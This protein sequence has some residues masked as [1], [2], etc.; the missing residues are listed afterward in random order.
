MKLTVF[1]GSPRGTRSNSKLILEQFLGG[2]C[3]TPG[4]EY[5]IFYLN[6]INSQSTLVEVFRRS[7][8]VL[9]AFPL[10]TD[11]MPGIVKAFFESL[12]PFRGQTGNPPVA[13][14]IQYGFSEGIHGQY[15]RRYL[16][17]LA[18]RLNSPLMGIATRGG[19][20]GIQAMPPIITKKLFKQFFELGKG[21]GSTGQFDAALVKTIAR[22]DRF[23]LTEI[24][25]EKVMRMLHVSN[26]YWDQMMKSN[27]AYEKRYDRPSTR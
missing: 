17:K 23:S 21:F 11:A 13:F 26:L 18:C 12:A 20:E 16:E 19:V 25:T 15:L 7:E 9:F 2:F 14:I 10:Y 8:A 22:K 6:N 27:N 4:N 24:I 3:K 5:E 1:N